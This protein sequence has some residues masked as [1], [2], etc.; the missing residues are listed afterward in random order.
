MEGAAS[1]GPVKRIGLDA[2]LTNQLSVGMK[3]Y[4]R[5]LAQRLPHVAPEFEY[6]PFPSGRNFGW[7]EQ[8]RLP[9]AMRR[10]R[11]DLMHFLSIYVPLAVPV[12]SVVTVHDLI[13]LRF[14]QYF[15]A[16]VR[17]YYQLVVR[18]ACA[19]AKRVIT[20]DE[21]TVDDLERFLGV[22]RAK[23]RVVPLGVD[24]R[25]TGA[26][27]PYAGPRP[28]VLYV[29]NHREHKNLATLFAAWSSLPMNLEVDLY[30][31]GP[32]DFNGELQGRSTSTR[33]AVALGDVPVQALAQ[34]YAGARALVQPAL[35]EGFGLPVLEAMAAGCVVVAS[36]EA[37]PGGLETAALTFDAGDAAQLTAQLEAAIAEEGPRRRL[38][39]AGRALA[40]AF[41]W[42][43]CARATA[44]VYREAMETP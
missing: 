31:T 32:D 18:L 35:R 8:I 36:K 6:V 12:R 27:V 5:E 37:I 40:A 19:R 20:D 21:R 10:A 25:F 28:Y 16:K 15:K 13:H 34:Y 14:P 3:T 41:G 9:L 39:S 38:V 43:R 17:P 7:D 33:A 4:V 24:E 1:A 11:L 30:L 42:D 26:I 29:G 23:V 44:D 2:R 22:S